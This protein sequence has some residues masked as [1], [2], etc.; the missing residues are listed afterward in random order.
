M[1]TLEDYS[2]GVSPAVQAVSEYFFEKG[3]GVGRAAPAAAAPA[4]LGNGE[5]GGALA[6]LSHRWASACAARCSSSARIIDLQKRSSSDVTV[7]L[8]VRLEGWAAQAEGERI[9][10]LALFDLDF[11]RAEST[12]EVNGADRP[13]SPHSAVT[14][15]NFPCPRFSSSRQGE[16]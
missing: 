16:K 8:E 3:M 12:A 1:P 9:A 14:S 6:E 5:G 2:F 7:R 11:G 4:A 15:R 13:A 10:A